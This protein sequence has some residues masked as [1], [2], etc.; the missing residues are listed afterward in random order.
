MY[1]RQFPKIAY[2]FDLSSSGKT[3]TATN[4][5]SRFRFNDSVLNNAYAF[6]KY[7]YQETDTPELVAFREYGDPQYYWVITMV[8]QMNDPLFEFPLQQDALERYI[9]KKYGYTSI[10]NSYSEI[11]HYELEIDRVLSEV[12]GATTTTTE[13]N[14]VTL[15]QYDY[16]SDTL[17]T[18]TANLP[19]QNALPIIFRANNSNA[20]S[21]TVATLTVT[22]TYKPV[23]VYDYE[24]EENE[25]KRQIR[26]LKRQYIQ[27]LMLEIETVLND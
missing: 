15:E 13:K 16:A 19:E 8:N 10:A 14:I 5:L 2:S 20:N 6:Y 22:S 1:F 7:E 12:D 4:I 26:L 27:P 23:Y 21:A 3:Y 17:V 24:L 9:I 25:K 18:K 11:H